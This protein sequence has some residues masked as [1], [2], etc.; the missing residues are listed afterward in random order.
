M[1][2]LQAPPAPPPCVLGVAPSRWA[3]VALCALALGVPGC[4]SPSGQPRNS[5]DLLQ[6]AWQCLGPRGLRARRLS[7]LTVRGWLFWTWPP[8]ARS[9]LFPAAPQAPLTCIH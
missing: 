2:S 1:G 4:I 3:L 9:Q 5:C 7:P 8:E 6:P